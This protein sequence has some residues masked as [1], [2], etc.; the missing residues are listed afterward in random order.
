[1]RLVELRNIRIGDFALRCVRREYGRAILRAVIGALIVQ[2]RR[3]VRDR[4]EDL[5]QLAG[6]HLRIRTD[7]A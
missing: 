4:K 2:L 1:M 7:S 3:I 5:Q 6:R